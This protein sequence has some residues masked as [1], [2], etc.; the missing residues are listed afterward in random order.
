MKRK[1]LEL[2]ISISEN[3]GQSIQ[4]YTD[5]IGSPYSYTHKL[6]QVLDKNQLIQQEKTNKSVVL[7][8]TEKGKGLIGPARLVL[9][10]NSET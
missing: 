6:V 4:Y 8:L 10:I 3:E 5:K 2:L 9:R 1:E 7:R